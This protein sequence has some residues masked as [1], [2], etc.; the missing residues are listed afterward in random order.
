[1]SISSRSTAAWYAPPRYTIN[2]SLPPI[3][4][5]QQLARDYNER[6]QNL[7]LLFDEVLEA[8]C[9][10]RSIGLIR[11][12]A[13]IFLRRLHSREETQELVGI[14]QITGIDLYLLV[15]FNVLLDIFMGCTSGAA[16]TVD[17]DGR[18]KMIHYRT[19]DWGMD[20]LRKVIVQL[21]FINYEKGPIIASSVTYAGYVGVLTGVRS[22]LSLSLNFRPNHDASTRYKNFRFY[23]H[24]LLVLTGVRPS[25]SS[26][27]RQCLLDSSTGKS[28]QFKDLD[29]IE[30]NLPTVHSTA[31]Y[32]IF[33]DGDRAIS[34]EKDRKTA[35]IRS[36]KDFIATT[37]HDVA[38][39]QQSKSDPSAVAM[40]VAQ[41]TGMA[42][43]VAE[44]SERKKCISDKWAR[45][46][47]KQGATETLGDKSVPVAVAQSQLTKWV[48]AYPTTN[49]ETHYSCTVDPK[50]GSFVWVRC[51]PEPCKTA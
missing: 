5:Y 35:L 37:N 42:I 23:L 22:G 26:I 10:K 25:I 34:L 45:A 3:Q 6:V 13:R 14:H 7:P 31:A 27:F 36:A 12:L 40:P 50:D 48:H 15:A 39:E 29:S 49:E 21:D 33:S 51:Y 44:S 11:R 28:S 46:A 30:R 9:P 24:H 32:L 18:Q 2:L 4:R 20:P 1:M 8:L 19:M 38:D 41:A 17:Q 47:K 43:S 16:R